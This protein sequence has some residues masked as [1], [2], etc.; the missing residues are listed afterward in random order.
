MQLIIAKDLISEPAN[1]L[2]P[3]SYADKCKNLNI[4]GL[5]VRTLDANQLKLIGMRSLLGVAQGS[6]N[7]P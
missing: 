7:E 3:I 1:I 2:N 5:K 4:K 6:Y